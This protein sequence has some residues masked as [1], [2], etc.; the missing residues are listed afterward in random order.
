MQFEFRCPCR[1][2]TNSNNRR[3]TQY[4][5]LCLDRHDSP[6]FGVSAVIWNKL[7]YKSED[8]KTEKYFLEYDRENNHYN[9]ITK[10]GADLACAGGFVKHVSD[11]SQNAME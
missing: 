6:L 1:F 4:K 8:R 7:V 3:K 11:V 10:V 9:A 5:Y 2:S